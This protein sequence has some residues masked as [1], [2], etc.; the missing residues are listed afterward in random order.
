[1]YD[2][3]N[4]E[5]LNS[6]ELP[7]LGESLTPLIRESSLLLPDSPAKSSPETGALQYRPLSLIVIYGPTTMIVS[8][9]NLEIEIWF[10]VQ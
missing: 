7:A 2:S 5:P 8:Q 1:M 4:F 10:L 3:N 6:P 9:T